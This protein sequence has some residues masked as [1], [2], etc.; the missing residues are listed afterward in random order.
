MFD[1]CLKRTFL[2]SHNCHFRAFVLI[3]DRE[4]KAENTLDASFYTKD[5]SFVMDMLMSGY[6]HKLSGMLHCTSK[7]RLGRWARQ[8]LPVSCISAC[9]TSISSTTSSSPP[10]KTS[11]SEL[12]RSEKSYIFRMT[13]KLLSSHSWASPFSLFFPFSLFANG[14]ITNFHLH[15]EQTVNELGKIAWVFPL[16]FSV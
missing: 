3:D 2:S 5:G 12:S 11:S 15:D 13:G 8:L 6:I 10:R 4:C 16:L 1:F 9:R 7:N 14:Q